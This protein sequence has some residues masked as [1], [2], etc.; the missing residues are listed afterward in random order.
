MSIA[1]R[2]HF[3]RSLPLS[4]FDIRVEF[5]N[6]CGNSR[7]DADSSV[8]KLENVSRKIK[9]LNKNVVI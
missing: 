2:I 5:S 9:D 6:P 3:H 8:V 1:S 7:I 4:G